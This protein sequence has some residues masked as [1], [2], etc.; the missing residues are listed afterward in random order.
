MVELL[1]ELG[2]SADLADDGEEALA[3]LSHRDYPLVLMDCQMPRKDGYET[4]AEIRRRE[5][6]RRRTPIVAVTA[7]ALSSERDK[8]LAAGM[9]DYLPKPVSIRALS[10]MLDHWWAPDLSDHIAPTPPRAE[11]VASAPE[12]GAARREELELTPAVIHAFLTHVPPQLKTI[13]DAIA[14]GDAAGLKKAAH[15]L[16]G[17]CFAVGISR[18]ASICRE[19][20]SIPENRAALFE[21]LSEEF[22]IVSARLSTQLARR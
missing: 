8:V 16:K 5:A 1:T 15:R 17:G 21:A 9:D 11:G 7:H 12:D 3:L 4:A 2:Y 14:A 18:M 6:G 20:E 10:E 13:G 22:G 19:L